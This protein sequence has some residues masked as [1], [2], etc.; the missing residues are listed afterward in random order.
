MSELLAIA[1][2]VH[3]IEYAKQRRREIGRGRRPATGPVGLIACIIATA[4]TDFF[5]PNPTHKVDAL[6]YFGSDLYQHH[7]S[8]LDLPYR[9]L[10]KGISLPEMEII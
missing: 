5:G 2:D 1:N 10:P 3:S 9:W 6:R 4:A 8:L 7:L